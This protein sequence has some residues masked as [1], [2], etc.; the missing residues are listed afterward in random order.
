MSQTETCHQVEPNST[1]RKGVW[2]TLAI[3]AVTGAGAVTIAL[4]ATSANADPPPVTTE[5]APPP[6][7]EASTPAPGTRLPQ[8]NHHTMP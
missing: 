3:A 8:P 2:V 4:P 7:P 6:A 1:R 5:Q